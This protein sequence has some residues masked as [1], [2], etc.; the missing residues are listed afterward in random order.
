MMLRHPVRFLLTATIVFAT[1]FVGHN[2][3]AKGAGPSIGPVPDIA[4]RALRADDLPDLIPVYGEG[5]EVLGYARA[6]E[7]FVELFDPSKDFTGFGIYAADGDTL[8]GHEI[9][10]VGFVEAAD[11]TPIESS[12]P[13]LIPD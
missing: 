1:V 11:P 5:D 2:V 3:S 7:A 8:L 10:G 6:E 13:A 4:D 12:A 9:P